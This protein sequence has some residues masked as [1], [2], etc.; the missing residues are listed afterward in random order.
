MISLNLSLLLV[1]AAILSSCL[2]CPEVCRCDVKRKIVYCNERNLSQIPYGIPLDTKTLRLQQNKLEN[3][4]RMESILGRL[5]VLQRLDFQSNRLSSFPNHL[6]A[7]LISL[8]LRQNLIKFVGKNPMKELNNLREL[9]LDF[10]NL[11]NRGIAFGAFNGAVSLQELTLSNNNLTRF[12]EGLPASIR[13][14]RISHN[15]INVVS[16]TST[17]CLKHL[18]TLD[19]SSNK[20]KKLLNSLHKLTNL[21]SLYLNHNM[22]TNL[23]RM[24]PTNLTELFLS[25]NHINYIFA[26]GSANSG[27]LKEMK[28]LKILDLSFNKLQGVQQGAL[29]SLPTSISVELQNNSWI[30][31]CNLVYLKQWLSDTN[32]ISSLN[33]ERV[34]LTCANPSALAGKNLLDVKTKALLCHSNYPVLHILKI[35]PSRVVI[36]YNKTK[37]NPPFMALNV[38]YGELLCRDCNFN[39][40][41][42]VTTNELANY[43]V[44]LISS[45]VPVE[46]SPLR[47]NSRYAVCIAEFD[48]N[49]DGTRTK[50]CRL[51]RT[52]Q[53]S[54]NS[55]SLVHSYSISMRVEVVGGVGLSLFVGLI[56]GLTAYCIWKRHRDHFTYMC[57]K[58]KIK[59]FSNEPTFNNSLPVVDANTE[60]DVTVIVRQHEPLHEHDLHVT[61]SSISLNHG[62]VI[63]L[64]DMKRFSS[65]EENNSDESNTLLLR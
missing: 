14:L 25:S 23:P 56:L 7:S 46:L 36:Y 43:S 19:L 63:S 10:N 54:S 17:A 20:I 48:Q 32:P 50:N 34:A 42:S 5:R 38:T 13:R 24:L 61:N 12:P 4:P 9:N 58:W 11:T 18:F 49:Y 15:H 55:D 41:L 64:K 26:D 39:S 65:R 52:L 37:L 53:R 33:K 16:Q 60:F 44:V 40:V 31:D 3:S 22:L 59:T 51:F 47:P 30:C 57:F 6:P 45:D 27:D 35:E 1:I 62:A 8:S 28:Q 2:S 21:K 29:S